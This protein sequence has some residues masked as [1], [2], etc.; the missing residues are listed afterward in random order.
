[1]FSQQ[2][3][4]IPRRL[5]LPDQKWRVLILLLIVQAFSIGI[6]IFCF[7]FWVE[8]WMNEFQVSRREVMIAVS[9]LTYVSGFASFF[10]GRWI[11]LYPA[12]YVVTGGLV[13]MVLGMFIV[14]LAQNIGTIW[15]VY[16]LILPACISLCGPLV[17]MTLVSRSFGA[18]RG[19]AM[20]LVTMGTS[21][22]GVIF[23]IVVAA[24]LNEFGWRST[25][26][27]IAAASGCL[28]LP[29]TWIILDKEPP[30]H[31]MGDVQN[32]TGSPPRM[33]GGFSFVLKGP[34]WILACAMLCAWWVFSSMQHNVRP[35]AS[36]L[37][38]STSAAAFLVSA[39]ALSMNAGKLI[40]ASLADQIDV[41]Y[42]LL[43]SK[44]LMAGS[45][46]SITLSTDYKLVLLSIALLGVAAGSFLPLQG[47]LHAGIYGTQ[48]MGRTM[49]MAAPI[50]SLSALGAFFAAWT[51][52][53]SGSYDLYFQSAAF[54]LL[55]TSVLLLVLPAPQLAKHNPRMGEQ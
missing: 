25:F 31:P 3:T 14:S 30:P 34:F 10:A 29:V 40:V 38:Y 27:I 42:L 28:L 48:M 39:M 4:S 15:L 33:K 5:S 12:K 55:L 16:A 19:L 18:R 54:A 45:L 9:A 44:V 32:V 8:P 47:S 52:D 37:G 26:V 17:A 43:G 1:M 23:P 11:D 46:L 7:T 51:R 53:A 2:T 24:L 35:F 41:R 49:G 50:Q 21:L 6:S 13:F 36:D 20:S 22:G